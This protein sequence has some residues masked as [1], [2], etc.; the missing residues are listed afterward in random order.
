[1]EE[2]DGHV[3]HGGKDSQDSPIETCV[4]RLMVN[5]TVHPPG[6]APVNPQPPPSRDVYLYFALSFSSLNFFSFFLLH[7]T[8]RLWIIFH[9]LVFIHNYLSRLLQVHSLFTLNPNITSIIPQPLS[10]HSP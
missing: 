8:K 7:L 6:V 4:W 9:Q 10:R 1:M 2:E 5:E 3:H